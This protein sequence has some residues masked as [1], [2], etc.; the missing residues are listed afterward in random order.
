[1]GRVPYSPRGVVCEYEERVGERSYRCSLDRW[2]V[3]AHDIRT[4]SA[5]NTFVHE[6]IPGVVFW[7]VVTIVVMLWRAS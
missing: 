5:L 6:I 3:G 1:M 4:E 2:H 7:L